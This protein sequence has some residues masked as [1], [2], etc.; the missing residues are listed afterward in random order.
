[1]P[2]RRYERREVIVCAFV[3][4]YGAED[5]GGIE[6]LA[7]P[8]NRDAGSL[9]MKA[10]NIAAM[11]E[12]HGLPHSLQVSPLTG[13]KRGEGVR[14]TDWDVVEPFTRLR[15]DEHLAVCRLY[16]QGR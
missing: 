11:L 9:R 15:K 13:K 8:L 6:R 2:A 16:L 5:L 1:M 12:A 7:M 10:Q 4:M 14:G 3:A